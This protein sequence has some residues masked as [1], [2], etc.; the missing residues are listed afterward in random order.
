MDIQDSHWNIKEG[1]IIRAYMPIGYY[2]KKALGQKDSSFIIDEKLIFS[3]VRFKAVGIEEYYIEREWIV[4]EEVKL[5]SS[6][7][8]S[9]EDDR[10][11]VFAYPHPVGFRI[12]DKGYDLSEISTLL[13]F[14]SA[15]TRKIK[16]ENNTF[17]QTVS[18]PLALGG[19]E[20]QIN[21]SVANLSRQMEIYDAINLDD[22]LLIRGL[23]AFLKGD[24]LSVHHIFHTEACISL[25]IA[26]EATLQI[27]LRRLRNNIHNPSNKDASE[28]L[29]N[30]FNSKYIPE[31]YFEDYYRDRIVAVHPSNR[32]GTFPDAPLSADDFYDLYEQLRSV[33]DFLITGNIRKSFCGD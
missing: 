28:Y 6:I 33:Y 14:Q 7:A 2:P 11:K 3:A 18:P 32:I 30:V 22:H 25:H 8:L 23:G 31:K 4:P 5:L 12:E 26:M 29:G 9:V 16:D 27:I 13:E 10:G 20:Y 15:L 17:W 19:P 1:I 21:E 24:L